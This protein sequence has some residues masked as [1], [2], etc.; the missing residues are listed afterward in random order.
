MPQH[1]YKAGGHDWLATWRDMYE[2][3]RAQGE[4]GTDP[5]FAVAPDHWQGQATRFAQA[6]VQAPQPDGFLRF[7]SPRLRPSDTLI[8]IGAGTGRYEPTLAPLVR[9]L[10]AVEPSAA[11]RQ[12][13]EPRCG[14]NGRVVAAGWPEADVPD[15]DIAIA[16]HVIYGVPEIQPFLER[17]N[18]VA[19]RGCYLLLAFRHPTSFASPFWHA[20]HG[21]VRLPLPGAL[22]CL[23]ALYQIG[24]AAQLTLV[25]I[26][27]RIQ[28]DDEESA[29]SDLR[30]RLRIPPDPDRDARLRTLIREQFEQ[31]PNGHI[32]P[33]G[34]PEQAAV[35]WWER[36]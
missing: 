10:I 31:L 4:S 30:W 11:M 8:D 20:I 18:A 9:E 12:Y 21:E 22:E 6:A 34:L 3:E 13:L 25:P 27:A 32:A 35:V 29:L 33:Q 26:D 2:R 36:T 7:L 19:R 16:A 5:G 23:N 15:C 28:F 17:M 1:S 14:P 24:I